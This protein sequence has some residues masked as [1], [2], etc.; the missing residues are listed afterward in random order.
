MANKTEKP[1]EITATR[2]IALNQINT[3]R[4]SE[5]SQFSVWCNTAYCGP[6][7]SGF[8]RLC[9]TCRRCS[10]TLYDIQAAWW[11]CFMLRVCTSLLR[12]MALSHLLLREI[13]SFIMSNF[14]LCTLGHKERTGARIFASA[15]IMYLQS[16]IIFQAIYNLLLLA[17]ITQ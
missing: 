5:R 4:I 3:H 12:C 8:L 16:S 17:A 14:S 10:N 11:W 2:A 15:P 7:L 9:Y 6:S 1:E 13:W